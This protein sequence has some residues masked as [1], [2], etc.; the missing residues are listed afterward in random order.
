MSFRRKLRNLP[1]ASGFSEVAEMPQIQ[2]PFG[3]TP[4][5]PIFGSGMTTILSFIAAAASA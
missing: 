1:A 3:L 2:V 4:F 5:L